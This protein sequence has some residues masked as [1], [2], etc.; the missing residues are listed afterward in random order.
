MVTTAAIIG[1]MM[2]FV[3]SPFNGP[4][5]K[6]LMAVNLTNAPIDF[7]GNPSIAL[8]TVIAVEIWKWLGPA[9]DLLAGR[10][11]NCPGIAL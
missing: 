6:L 1:I 2:T 4:L 3:L 9:H 7:L 8:Y 5:N 11:A 10:T